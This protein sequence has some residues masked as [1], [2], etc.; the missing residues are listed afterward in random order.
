MSDQGAANRNAVT[1]GTN[2]A[3]PP[4]D[5]L[6]PGTVVN[7]FVIERKLGHGGMGTVYGATH[8]VIG[9][10]GAIKVLRMELC[11]DQ[12]EVGRFVQ[13]ARAVNQIGHP[14][15]V[16]VFAFGTLPDGRSYLIMEW[17]T[18]ESL[19]TRMRG[20]RGGILSRREVR[21]VIDDVVR[22]LEATHAKGIIHRDLK[23]DNVFLVDVHGERPRAKLLD[24]GVAKLTG[25]GRLDRTRVG[26]ML[27][28]PQY[29]SP[30]QARGEAD[31]RA[32]I[33]ALGI[34]LF[35]LVSGRL[36]FI[37]G[38]A[39]EVISLHLLEK[40]PR[41]SSVAR[42]VSPIL[43]NLVDAMLSKEPADRPSL[44]R[45]RAQLGAL[46]TGADAYKTGVRTLTGSTPARPPA[47]LGIKLAIA[48]LLGIVATLVT[49]WLLQDG[50][51]PETVDAAQVATAD[52]GAQTPTKPPP[53][54]TPPPQQ[55][56]PI[57]F[58][59]PVKV[60]AP[61]PATQG[62]LVIHPK[63]PGAEL[64]V[65][66]KAA[67]ANQPIA[68]SPGRHLVVATAKNRST[69][70]TVVIQSGRQREVS[71]GARAEAPSVDDPENNGLR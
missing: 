60:V 68:L 61:E 36:P 15:I 64:T 49:V 65:D 17:L 32:D 44:S 38:N 5:E 13:E 51:S 19:R 71:I 14:N 33:Y 46:V 30:E 21:D 18:G 34:M 70:M 25:E 9:K 67:T 10:R 40:P 16:D 69:R 22:A 57:P 2:A 1:A 8:P 63:Q 54:P 23:P 12:K 37:G 56:P 48:A 20:T 47:R 31:V 24:F 58:S 6:A 28:T 45:I 26:S 3:L 35:E 39:V 53:R 52:A 4:D 50:N 62:T 66:G 42:D 43:D 59:R 27:G 55:Q 7:E 29:I 11:T 41:L